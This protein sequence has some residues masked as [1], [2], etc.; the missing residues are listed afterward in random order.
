MNSGLSTRP[1]TLEEIKEIYSPRRVYSE[2]NQY[3]INPLNHTEGPVPFALPQDLPIDRQGQLVDPTIA[4]PISKFSLC[5]R[6]GITRKDSF[7]IHVGQKQ[8]IKGRKYRL[9]L[10]THQDADAMRLEIH[11]SGVPA[12]GHH[13]Q[14]LTAEQIPG[15]VLVYD[16][17][18]LNGIHWID[19]W[20]VEIDERAK[21]LIQLHNEYQR[22]RLAKL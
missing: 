13:H 10:G 15:K 7:F 5:N 2:N 14:P 20:L 3:I 16:S 1:F 17:R 11:Y 21:E 9:I 8:H 22:L 18:S 6:M 19:F 12:W 4:T